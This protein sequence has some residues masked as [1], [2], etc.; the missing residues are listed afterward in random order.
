MDDD[1]PF[2]PLTVETMPCKYRTLFSVE[3]AAGFLLGGWPPDDRSKT[4]L[5][6]L[7]ACLEALEGKAP[8]A[9]ARKCFLD[10]ALEAGVFLR[11]GEFPWRR[12]D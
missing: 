6:A 9:K 3:D 12:K 8:A 11:E 10:A 5:V 7:R 4:R 1:P 2:R